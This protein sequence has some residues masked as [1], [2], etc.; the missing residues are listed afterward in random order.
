MDFSSDFPVGKQTNIRRTIKSATNK[1]VQNKDRLG[2][3]M[4]PITIPRVK[5]TVSIYNGCLGTFTYLR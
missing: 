5:N 4:E 2:E 1:M 3:Q